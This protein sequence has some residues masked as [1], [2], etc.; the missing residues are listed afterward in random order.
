MVGRLRSGDEP[1]HSAMD[2]ASRGYA[3]SATWERAIG[4]DVPANIP[5]ES[6]AERRRNYA[7]LLAA[8]VRLSFPTTVVGQ[9]VRDGEVP[10]HVTDDVRS[11][12][13]TF[14]FEHAKGFQLGI[15]PVDQ[16]LKR[17][18]LADEVGDEIV[19]EVRR[20]Q[21]VFQ[22]TPDDAA[23][24]AL[25]SEDLDSAYKVS[26]WTKASFAPIRRSPGRSRQGDGDIPKGT[27]GARRD[28]ERCGHVHDDT[29]R[30]D[31]RRSSN[32]TDDGCRAACDDW[33]GCWGGRRRWHSGQRECRCLSD[34]GA[35]V[36][37]D[38]LLLLP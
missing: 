28:P 21:R 15:E 6:I 16:Y 14:L 24:S 25:M 4:D 5:G 20:I 12:V 19:H 18:K 31:D 11:A 9:M 8:Q 30:P 7:D 1:I 27:P 13:S 3:R 17:S 37:L 35:V 23:M 29:Q 2:L 32:A 38:G 10:L 36:R 26:S 34:A 22:I 33:T